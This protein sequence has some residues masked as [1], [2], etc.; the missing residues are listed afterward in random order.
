MRE[1]EILKLCMLA[2]AECGVTLLRNNRGMFLT[3]DGKRKV[4]AGL[5]AAGSAD[6][7]GWDSQGKFVACEIK[8]STGHVSPEQKKFLD[9]VKSAGG[10]AFIARSPE[11]VKINLNSA[12]L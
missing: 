12:L 2:A 3:L 1:S 5:E 7:I 6:L 11:D 4:R 10:I 8:T 9:A